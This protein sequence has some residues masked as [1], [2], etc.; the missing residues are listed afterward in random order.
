MIRLASYAALLLITA[1]ASAPRPALLGQID[2]IRDSDGARES[3]QLVPQADA[4]AEKLRTDAE[5]AW[6]KG[7]TA[8]AE[9]LAER[10]LVA[11]SDARELSRIVRVEQRLL[12]TKAEVHRAELALQKLQA[13]QKSAAA[14][15]ADLEARLRVEREAQEPAD[16]LPSTPDREHARL[17]A[18]KTALSQ[19]RLLCVSARLLRGSAPEPDLGIDAALTEI[20]GVDA[21]VVAGKSPAPI[22]EAIAARSRCQQLLTTQRRPAV[23]ANP[24][25]EKSDQLFVELA[26]AGF[27]PSRDDRG[28]VVTLNGAFAGNGI[29]S[30]TL[31]RLTDLG[32]LAQTHDQTPIL[33]V[34]HA[35]K[36]EPKPIDQQRGDAA[37][38]RLKEAGVSQVQIQAVGGRLPVAEGKDLGANRR[39]ERLE[40]IF[41]TRL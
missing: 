8:S 34:T 30:Q 31:T 39:N 3:R 36:G 14:E 6:P 13:D 18:A 15:A 17:V 21:K 28:I 9:I 11:Y 19:A 4:R 32:R 16:P 1:C 7:Q 27:A 2:A 24:T 26:N 35:T 40:L 22:R 12:A 33:V 37:A 41:V 38:A 5:A 20:T 29:E 25:S 23:M 10:A